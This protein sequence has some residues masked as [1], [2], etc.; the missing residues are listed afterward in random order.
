MASKFANV[1]D[2]AL[3]AHAVLSL[4][5]HASRG[6]TAAA[7]AAGK[8]MLGIELAAPLPI[9]DLS[10]GRID[11]ALDELRLLAP[12]ER[13]RIVRACLDS[14]QADGRINIAEAELVR[15][16]AAALDCPLPPMLD[17][18]DPSTLA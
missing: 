4:V 16:V 10:A 7:F 15:A 11:Q 14:A 17:A 9:S 12:L 6:D 1:S 2:V 8:R 5:S 3:S 18:L 13:P